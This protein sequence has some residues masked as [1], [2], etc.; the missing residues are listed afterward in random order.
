[1]CRER[2]QGVLVKEGTRP[3]LSALGVAAVA[4]IS[5]GAVALPVLSLLLVRGHSLNLRG[6]A[7]LWDSDNW[8]VKAIRRKT[9]GTGKMRYLRHVP[10]RF[11]TGFRE[12]T[13]AA[14]RKKDE[15][16]VLK[17]DA[18]NVICKLREGLG[19]ATN[20]AA[21]YRAIILRLDGF[22]VL[23]DFQM[24]AF[25]KMLI[26][27]KG[28]LCNLSKTF[29]LRSTTDLGPLNLDSFRKGNLSAS[30][31]V[32]GVETSVQDNAISKSNQKATDLKQE[33][34][35][36]KEE[37]F[38]DDDH[39]HDTPAKILRRQLRDNRREKRATELVKQDEKVTVKLENAAIEQ[40]KAVDSA[41]YNLSKDHKSEPEL[42]KDRILKAGGFI[43]VG[44][45]NGSLNMARAVGTFWR[46]RCAELKQNK[47]LPAEKQI[48]TA[49]PDINAVSE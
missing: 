13:E 24:V 27:E 2:E 42:E 9:T 30:W 11:K 12:G 6:I 25:C 1:M 8:S 40:S 29:S 21:E 47:T 7:L 37:K 14:P 18:G 34:S 46:F 5:R 22:F 32:V 31:K 17:T 39:S 36:D 4:S 16:F 35:Q 3:T 44:R 38:L 28:W 48:V 45:I 23:Y 20:N 15:C 26:G 43:Q 33:T 49:N 10:R 41:A 19:I